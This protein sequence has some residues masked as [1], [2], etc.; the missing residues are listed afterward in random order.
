M[1]KRLRWWWRTNKTFLLETVLEDVLKGL[2][3]V[4]ISETVWNGFIVVGLIVLEEEERRMMKAYM[5]KSHSM[6]WQ[7][8][9]W[10]LA[11]SRT[12]CVSD[13]IQKKWS[14]EM[15]ISISATV[16]HFHTLLT[17]VYFNGLILSWCKHIKRIYMNTIIWFLLN[18][19]KK[20]RTLC[21]TL[22]KRSV[23]LQRVLPVNVLL[24]VL[25]C[26]MWRGWRLDQIIRAP[27][28]W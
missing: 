2:L 1:E 25:Q 26:F 6:V 15:T 3:L 17:I 9:L 12:L 28:K 13:H 8:G 24:N 23:L 22:H 5:C 10:C 18:K 20:W 16:F 11:I 7:S 19:Q 4:G 27:L 21:L 14:G